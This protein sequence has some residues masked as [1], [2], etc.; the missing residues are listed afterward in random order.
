MIM[1]QT[2]LYLLPNFLP[3]FQHVSGVYFLGF[4]LVIEIVLVVEGEELVAG[5][6]IHFDQVFVD[7]LLVGIFVMAKDTFCVFLFRAFEGGDAL[8]HIATFVEQHVRSRAVRLSQA[9]PRR[10][11]A[12]PSAKWTSSS[13]VGGIRLNQRYRSLN[14]SGRWRLL[15]T[16]SVL[17]ELLF[18][19]WIQVIH[20]VIVLVHPMM[21]SRRY[22]LQLT[23]HGLRYVPIKSRV[24]L[25]CFVSKEYV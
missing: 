1:S 18:P 16:A 9:N 22:T 20:V 6:S 12:P 25:F 23:P 19:R 24:L 7:F 10:G 8:E 5:F 17:Q 21:V 3:P 15:R 14:P 13:G 2:M 4:D 11:R